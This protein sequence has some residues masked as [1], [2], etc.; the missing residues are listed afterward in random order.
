MSSLPRKIIDKQIV[1]LTTTTETLPV[2]AIIG[3][4]CLIYMVQEC[5]ATFFPNPF[6][7]RPY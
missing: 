6:S 7:R 1:P 5:P 3:K 4:S 2:S